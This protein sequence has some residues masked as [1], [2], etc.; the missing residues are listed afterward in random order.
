M[1]ILGS[2][3]A[4]ESPGYEDL[5]YETVGETVLHMTSTPGGAPM[6]LGRDP[7][8]QSRHCSRGRP[9]VIARDDDFI[10]LRYRDYPKYGKFVRHRAAVALI[11]APAQ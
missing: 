6:R 3:P 10:T 2:P 5:I 4:R 11:P 7:T 1:A 9:I 8:R